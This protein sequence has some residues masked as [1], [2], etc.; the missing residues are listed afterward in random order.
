MT[1]SAAAVASLTALIA[2]TDTTPG[3]LFAL[4]KDMKELTDAGFALSNEEIKNP[5]NAKEIA[6]KVTDAG[7]AAVKGQGQNASQA[8]AKPTFAVAKVAMPPIARANAEGSKYPFADLDNEYGFFIPS[9]AKNASKSFGSLVSAENKKY[10]KNDASF[11]RFTSRTMTGDAFDPDGKLGL[12]GK[13]GVGVFRLS[14]ADEAKAK[15]KAFPPATA[16]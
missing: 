15:A 5:N 9:D 16:A 12:K 14:A 1:T 4:P 2:A 6:F 7:R 13:K 11:R 3:Y 8:G 10:A